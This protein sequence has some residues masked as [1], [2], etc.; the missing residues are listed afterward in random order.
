MITTNIPECTA[1]KSA[2]D[3]L[4]EYILQQLTENGVAYF[5][6]YTADQNHS[7]TTVGDWKESTGDWSGDFRGKDHKSSLD[8]VKSVIYAFKQKG[9]LVKNMFTYAHFNQVTI[10]K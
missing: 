6:Y 7:T 3:E 10:S 5:K 8:A 9:Y 4:V 1:R 2:E